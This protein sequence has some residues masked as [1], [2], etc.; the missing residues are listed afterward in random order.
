MNNQLILENFLEVLASEKGLAVNTRI[1]YKNDILQF[2]VFLEKN[3]KKINEITT[4]DI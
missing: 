3:K 4:I 2:L 1:S